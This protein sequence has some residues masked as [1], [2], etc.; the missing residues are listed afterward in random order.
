MLN[1]PLVHL[2]LSEWQAGIRGVREVNDAAST[3]MTV[4][5]AQVQERIWGPRITGCSGEDNRREGID[6]A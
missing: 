4:L 3:V 1:W 5:I 2:H 6:D